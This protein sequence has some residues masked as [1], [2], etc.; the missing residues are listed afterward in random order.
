MIEVIKDYSGL[1][2][3]KIEEAI[4]L[5]NIEGLKLLLEIEKKVK[6]KNVGNY[7]WAY[8]M[9]LKYNF[10]LSNKKGT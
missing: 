2:D 9:A 8:S 6:I 1:Y 4:K 3:E 7:S 10:N 5:G